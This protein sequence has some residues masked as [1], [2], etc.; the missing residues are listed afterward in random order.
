MA[1]IRFLPMDRAQGIG[2]M[3]IGVAAPLTPGPRVG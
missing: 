2:T 1:A 3:T